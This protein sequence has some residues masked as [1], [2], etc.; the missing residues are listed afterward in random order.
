VT[1]KIGQRFLV[2]RAVRAS[3][4]LTAPQKLVMLV[5]LDVAE[6]GTAEIPSHRTPS[7]TVLTV[8]TG[9]S[10]STVAKALNVL[11]AAGWVLRDRPS[12]ADALGRYMRT[13]YRLQVPTVDPSAGDGLIPEED[14]SR[15]GTSPSATDTDPSATDGPPSAGDG[16]RSNRSSVDK[17]QMKNRSRPKTDVATVDRIDIEQVCRHLADRIEANGSKRPTITQGWRDAAR[18]LIDKDGRT[19]EQIIRCID[20]CQDDDFWR[21]NVLSMPKLREKYDAL[22]LQAQR[23]QAN[24]HRPS[25]TDQRVAQAQALKARFREMP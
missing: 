16:H 6:V 11:E 5:L 2:S 12:D 23:G 14:Q 8:E 25:T 4:T 15:N 10:R 13:R 1:E 17:T 7:L 9:L 20:W 18:R 21:S 19:V 3:R 22:R 24:G